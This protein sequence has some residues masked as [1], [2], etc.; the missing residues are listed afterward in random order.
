VRQESVKEK[1]SRALTCQVD[2]P[3]RAPVSGVKE[4]EKDQEKEEEK[5]RDLVASPADQVLVQAAR[6]AASRH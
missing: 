6:M 3:L 2:R 1:L 5:V 4:Q